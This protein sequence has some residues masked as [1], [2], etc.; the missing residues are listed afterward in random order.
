MESSS[1][2]SPATPDCLIANYVVYKVIRIQSEIIM[3]ISPMTLTLTALELTLGRSLI[4][5][6]G[7]A[8]GM[9]THRQINQG[10]KGQLS[11]LRIIR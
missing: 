8:T 4:A 5:L 2:D 10:R 11:R 6:W 9:C 1:E 7:Q 3:R